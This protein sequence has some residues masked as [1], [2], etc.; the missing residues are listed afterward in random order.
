MRPYNTKSFCFDDILI[1]PQTSHVESRHK[2]DL[3]MSI[4]YGEREIVLGL[5][6][7]AAPMDTVCD[8]EMA[9]VMSNAGGLGILHR[10][11]PEKILVEK[12]QRLS[13]AGYRFGVSVGATN[14]YMNVAEDLYSVGARIILVDIA[15]GHSVYAINAVENLRKRMP[16]DLHIMAGNVATAE[17]FARLAD[18]GADSVR[19]GIGGGSACTTR[20]VSGHGVPTLGSI[21]DIS[22][23]MMFADN[24]TCSIIADGGIRNTG[25]MIKAFAA[26]ADAVMVGS[27][28]AGTDESP[29]EI[30]IDANGNEGKMFRGMAS[31][32]AQNDKQGRVSVA[33]GIS[34]TIL[35]KGS[36]KH[37][38]DS[39]RGG[40]GSGCSYS[41]VESLSELY[42]KAEYVEVNFASIQES[43][44]H[45]T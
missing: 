22:D 41:G 37:I 13:D 6:V 45:A 44:P 28:F 16:N 21:M 9:M 4:G 29:G 8:F 12:A 11:M 33:E 24:E 42:D 34:T 35:Y 14:G 36:M 30:L 3:S 25:D 38:L 2:V 17:G 23:Y 43:R 39:I 18:V 19:V 40:L 5:P 31:A 20:I 10:Y 7:I 1:V 15:N 32:A 27:M 26:G